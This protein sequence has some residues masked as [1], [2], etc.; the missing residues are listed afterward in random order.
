MA[1]ILV[2]NN[3]AWHTILATPNKLMGAFGLEI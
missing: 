1:N 3:G 2:E